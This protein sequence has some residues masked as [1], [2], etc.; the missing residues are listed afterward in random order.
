MREARKIKL[1]SAK[2]NTPK[3]G[4]EDQIE[5]EVDEVVALMPGDKILIRFNQRRRTFAGLYIL[6]T[7]E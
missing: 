7:K 2:A 4:Q 3:P 6:N 1:T 5:L